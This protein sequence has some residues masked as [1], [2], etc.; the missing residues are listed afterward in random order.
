[1]AVA[2]HQLRI[3]GPPAGFSLQSVERTAPSLDV[4]FARRII[5]RFRV[6]PSQLALIDKASPHARFDLMLTVLSPG[7]TT[8]DRGRDAATT[9]QAPTRVLW[10]TAAN[11]HRFVS[12]P[13]QQTAFGLGGGALHLAVN[14]D[15]NTLDRE[16]VQ[17]LKQPHLHLIYWHAA[18]LAPLTNPGHLADQ[19][20]PYQRRQCID[21][22]SFLGSQLLDEMIG[23]ADVPLS[24]AVPIKPNI[25]AMLRGSLPIGAFLKLRGWEQLAEPGFATLIETLDKRID[26]AAKALMQA[27]AGSEQSPAPWHRHRLLRQTDI[28]ARLGRLGLSP[29]LRTRLLALASALRDLSPDASERLQRATAAQRQHCMTLNQP[30]YSLSLSP[31]NWQP[32]DSGSSAQSPPTLSLQLKLFSGV[33]GAGLLSLPGIPSVLVRRG[34][35]RFGREDWHL[36]TQFQRGFAAFNRQRLLEQR[37]DNLDLQPGPIANLSDF[38]RGWTL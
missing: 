34:Q 18:E 21:P 17:A 1:M 27:F 36:R 12:D 35:G 22:L 30:C 32:S 37:P 7:P 20:D 8:P 26:A 3:P 33:G 5:Q 6:G 15:P 16:S 28:A 2:W 4:R 13:E 25:G 31:F 19:T 38:D 9:E 23:L 11:F 29:S 24:G 10:Q 14:R